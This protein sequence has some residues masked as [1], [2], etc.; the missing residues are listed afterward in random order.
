[1]P[2]LPVPD[3][4]QLAS[5]VGARAGALLVV[6]GAGVSLASGISTF[7]GTD[8]GAVWANDVTELG[9][10]RYFERDPVGSWSWYLRRFDLFRAAEPNA[11]HTALVGIERWKRGASAKNN[12]LLVTQNIDGLHRAAGSELLVEVHGSAHRVRC[13][14]SGCANGAPTGTLPREQF[15]FD[16]FLANPRPETIP[17]CPEC[18]APMRPHVLWFD[19]LYGE[20]LDYRFDAVQGAAQQA[21]VVLFVGTSF[22]VGVTELLLDAAAARRIPAWSIDPVGSAPGRV[23]ALAAKA[24]EVLPALL[25]RLVGA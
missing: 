20:H 19:E 24:E 14:R 17:R 15:N 18:G 23:R 3:V 11:A 8:P 13:S 6:T 10:R 1:M 5:E 25:E 22:S 2:E 4:D 9:T 7:R 21:A 16:R 12:F